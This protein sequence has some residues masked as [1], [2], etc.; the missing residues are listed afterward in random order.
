MLFRS[1]D[2]GIEVV[3]FL[4]NGSDETLQFQLPGEFA[5]R[6]AIDSARPELDDEPIA[7]AEYTVEHNS[8]AVL[9]A[10]IAPAPT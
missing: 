4:I 6:A 9:I 10:H 8:A 7:G 2:D 3:A 1:E 5:W